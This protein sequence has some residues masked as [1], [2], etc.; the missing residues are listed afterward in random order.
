MTHFIRK[1]DR[2]STRGPAPSGQHAG[3]ARLWPVF[4]GIFPAQSTS[5]LL[6]RVRAMQKIWLALVPCTTAR[7]EDTLGRS[8]QRFY[9]VVIE[10]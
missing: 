1:P 3:E 2:Q 8:T 4:H 7:T 6:L 10:S 5:W 9:R